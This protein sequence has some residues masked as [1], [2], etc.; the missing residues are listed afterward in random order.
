MIDALDLFRAFQ[1][2]RGDAIVSATGT[3]G[4]HWKDVSRNEKR[5]I[6]LGGAMGH[7]ASAAFGLAM[8]LPDEKIILFDAEG[9]LLMNRPFSIQIGN[10]VSRKETCSRSSLA[11]TTRSFTAEY[12]WRTLIE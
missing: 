9:S 1:P 5:D 8:G 6:A 2:H 11:F 12:D 10:I 7:T 4:R 3:A